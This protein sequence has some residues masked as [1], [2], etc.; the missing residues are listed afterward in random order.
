MKKL[1]VFGLAATFFLAC[2][3]DGN[4]N[5]D[6]QT[7]ASTEETTTAEVMTVEEYDPHRGEGKFKDVELGA[8]D[9][10]KAAKGKVSYEMKCS[11]CHKLTDET[12]VGPGWKGVS[13][14]HHP[15][16]LLNFITNPDPMIDKDPELQKQLEVC[17][18]RMP[19]QNI[20][21]DEAFA[22]VEFMRQNDGVK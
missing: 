15:D 1:F 18:V 22:I 11:S 12:L 7:P 8:L 13:K 17:M 21:D 10:A 16:W 5:K 2:G 20:E 9:P 14:K 19:N 4:T 3:N 6:E